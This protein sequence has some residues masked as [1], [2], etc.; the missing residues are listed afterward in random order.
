VKR[1]DVASASRY[2]HGSMPLGRCRL[3]LRDEE[4]RDSHLL[5][6]GFYRLAR[7]PADDNPN[8]VVA[9]AGVTMKSSRAVKSHALCGE[10]E[11]RFS[12]R[13]E[14][15]VLKNCLRDRE[16]F[17]IQ[18]ALVRGQPIHVDLKDNIAVFAGNATAGVDPDQLSYFAA[19]VFW[20]AAAHT[21]MMAKNQRLKL[22]LGPYEESL[23]L[24]LRDEA[25]FPTDVAILVGVAQASTLENFTALPTM[26]GRDGHYRVY[27]F[28]VPGVTFL[29]LVGRA[30]TRGHRDLC[31][32]RSPER[33]ILVGD[34]VEKTNTRLA[35]KLFGHTRVHPNVRGART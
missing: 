20:R 28:K 14:D 6:A 12:T 34:L 25:P 30:L 7:S 23:R 22:A 10:C 29:L 16:G 17:A 32:I 1:R 27:W 11:Q 33:R 31:V 2:D 15:W 26:I 8:P 5:A 13:G 9:T 4:L 35:L 21:W 18:D 3:C 24:F 19:S